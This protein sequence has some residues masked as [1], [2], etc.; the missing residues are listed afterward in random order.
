MAT[1]R[2]NKIVIIGC[3]NVAWHIAKRFHALKGYSLSVYN[4]HPNPLLNAFRS[5]LKCKTA[6]GLQ[7]IEQDA[8]VYLI[9]V[10]DKAIAEVSEKIHCRKPGALV[11]H[12]SGSMP[13]SALAC[14]HPHKGVF[15]P[16]QTFSRGDAVVWSEIPL[17]L[18]AATATAKSKVTAMAKEFSSHLSFLGY[19]QRLNLHLAAVFVNNFSNALYAAALDLTPEKEKGMPLLLP[20]IRRT[21]AKLE[22]LTPLKAQTGPAKRGDKKVLKKHAELLAERP[23]LKKIYKLM[24]QLIVK[25]QEHA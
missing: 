3:G 15:Y 20:L 12:T 7:D 1:P 24:S 2:A 5:Q 17:V 23:E 8:D 14:I 21:T 6:A 19:K 4:H 18:E 11:A 25:Q 16:L 22:H 9:C 13:L 10:S